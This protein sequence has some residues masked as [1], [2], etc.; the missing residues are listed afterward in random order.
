MYIYIYKPSLIGLL[1]IKV[2]LYAWIDACWVSRAE[3]YVF[4]HFQL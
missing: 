2:G 1:N 3:I 4:K